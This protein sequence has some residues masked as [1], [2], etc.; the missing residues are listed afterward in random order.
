MISWACIQCGDVAQLA[1]ASGGREG[2]FLADF[3]RN[4]LDG[5]RTGNRGP[6]R[7]QLDESKLDPRGRDSVAFPCSFAYKRLRLS[8]QVR[9]GGFIHRPLDRLDPDGNRR[10]LAYVTGPSGPQER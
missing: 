5:R 10:F 6:A 4:S 1:T 9:Y 2:E 7:R 3:A 8:A